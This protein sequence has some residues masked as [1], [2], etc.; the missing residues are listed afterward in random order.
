MDKQI[1]VT[2][3]TILIAFLLVLGAYVLYRLGPVIGLFIISLIIV[4]SVEHAVKKLM[5]VTFLN[6]PLNRGTAVVLTYLLIV[7]VLLAIFTIGLPPVLM[8]AQSLLSSISTLPET[9][10]IGKNIEIS[11]VDLVPQFSELSRNLFSATYSIF[12]QFTAIVSILVISIYMS[13]DWLNLKS[14]FINLFPEYLRD[15]V[16]DI[17]YSVEQNV[18]HWVKGQLVLML[19]VGA[20]S[21]AALVLLGIRYPLPLALLAGLLEVIPILGPVISVVLASIVAFVQA[22]VK[23][24]LVFAAFVVIQ[25]IENNLLVPKVMQKVSGFS[26]LVILFAVLTGTRFFGVIGAILAVPVVM[27]VV[28]IV[29]RIL[30][31]PRN[32]S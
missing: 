12:S 6:K 21:F 30:G 23:G 13:I 15:E 9:L 10:Q 5:Q 18:G 17:I 16:D 27:I 8:Q 22:P 3:R 29:R 7:L 14:L 26:P 19:L 11:L 31:Y 2:I 20:M 25:Q 1:I 24:V 28:V 32:D 4:I